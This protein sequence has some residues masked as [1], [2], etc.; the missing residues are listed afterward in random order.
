MTLIL[1]GTDG[2]SDVDGSAATPAI[3]GTDAN[4][5]I[6]F[7]AAD[8]VAITTGGTQRAVVDASGNV[9]I[10]TSSPSQ[11]LE[12]T[13]NIL[14]NTSGNPSMTVKTSGAGNNPSYR[15]QADTTYWDIGASFSDATDPL[16]FNYGGTERARIDSAGSLLLGTTVT[17]N[18][19][20]LAVV[21]SATQASFG[22]SAN[23]GAFIISTGSSQAI[24][25]GGGYWSG[26]NWIATAT[27]F[28]SMEHSAGAVQFF[29]NTGLTAGNSFSPAE[30]ARIDSSG[31][32]LFNSGYGSVA[33]AYGC[34][35]WVN[36]NG[37]GTVAI[38][39]SGNVTSITDNGTGDY[40]VNF[41][42]AMPDANYSQNVSCKRSGT[43]S[44]LI[45]S[46]TQG[47]TATTTQCHVFSGTAGNT[48]AAEDSIEVAVS[49]FR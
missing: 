44:G 49:I 4:T 36:F 20:R 31:N 17:P 38:R 39:A 45:A 33:T 30:R 22:S 11:K 25:A 37:T 1:S 18:V 2:L 26:S 23:S 9:G 43:N 27:T 14:I 24:F 32:L 35:A 29:T 7:P 6:F 12:V 41:T 34:R 28:S 46:I 10:G 48:Y 15:L 19:Q 8:Q 21:S 40:T 13:G 42:T 47:R 3:R 5:G 16:T